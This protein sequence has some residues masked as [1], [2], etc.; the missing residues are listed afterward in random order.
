VCRE[1]VTGFKVRG[2][3]GSQKKNI[4]GA[5]KKTFIKMRVRKAVGMWFAKGQCND[6]AGYRGE[7]VH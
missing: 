3:K 4:G 7:T 2:Q 5:K 1:G 6:H